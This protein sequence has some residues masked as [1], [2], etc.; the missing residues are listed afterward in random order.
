MLVY[1]SNPSLLLF[2]NLTRLTSWSLLVFLIPFLHI[3][4]LSLHSS[5]HS[6]QKKKREQEAPNLI[7]LGETNIL[8][9]R[10]KFM[11]LGSYRSLLL[12]LSG[13]NSQKYWKSLFCLDDVFVFG[14]FCLLVFY[15][16]YSL[17]S[18]FD[19]FQVMHHTLHCTSTEW[20][21]Y[22]FLL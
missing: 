12:F 14:F 2:T 19:T 13:S 15:C 11:N 8:G 5:S 6:R 18:L 9:L 7:C 22:W 20:W 17:H 21:I 1:L 10:D 16:A 3:W 4:K